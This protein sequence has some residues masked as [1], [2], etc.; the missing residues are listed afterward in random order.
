MFSFTFYSKET[1]AGGHVTHPRSVSQRQT[2]PSL[3]FKNLG[4]FQET[5]LLLGYSCATQKQG[6]EGIKEFLQLEVSEIHV[7]M[8]GMKCKR[9][10]KTPL[11]NE[12]NRQTMNNRTNCTALGEKSCGQVDK[13]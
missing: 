13:L 5:P 11:R 1:E 2:D 10:K 12:K 3:G 4:S 6:K 7:Q 8:N 9:R